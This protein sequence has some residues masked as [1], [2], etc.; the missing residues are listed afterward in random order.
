[1]SRSTDLELAI[2]DATAP[3]KRGPIGKLFRMV[4]FPFRAIAGLIGAALGLVTGLAKV[5]L[6]PFRLAFAV[7]RRIVTLVSDVVYGI[8]RLI[9]GIVGMFVS[10]ILFLIGI[11]IGTIKLAV[12]A[13]LGVLKIPFKIL[14][15]VFWFGKKVGRRNA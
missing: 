7:T 12:R 10:V 13:V 9:A 14:G 6:L 5:V 8:F 1:M 3:T 11:V 15:P 2:L 4:T